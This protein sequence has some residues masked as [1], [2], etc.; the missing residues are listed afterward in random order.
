MPY[1]SRL[2]HTSPPGQTGLY[3]VAWPLRGAIAVIPLPDESS[4]SER[5]GHLGEKG[6]QAA[7][8]MLICDGWWCPGP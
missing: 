5:L 4:S 3:S 2:A 8:T 1:M 7:P 6:G